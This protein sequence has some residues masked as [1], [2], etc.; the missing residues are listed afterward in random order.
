MMQVDQSPGKGDVT[1]GIKKKSYS[2]EGCFPEGINSHDACSPN[3]IQ[4][5]DFLQEC[6]VGFF[7][8]FSNLVFDY[9]FEQN[10]LNSN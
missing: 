6:L 8:K 9:I 1:T 3:R 7:A 5:P 2:D 4:P 10:L